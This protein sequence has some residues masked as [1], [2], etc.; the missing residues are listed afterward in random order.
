MIDINKAINTV[1]KYCSDN[2]P[3]DLL[4]IMRFEE[5]DHVTIERAKDH[6]GRIEFLQDVGAFVVYSAPFDNSYSDNIKRFSL[7]HELGHYFLELHRTLLVRGNSHNASDQFYH[8]EKFEQ[9]AD[10]FAG[11]LLIPPNY[12]MK[13]IGTKNSLTL[14]D[15][16]NIATECQT[17]LTCAVMRYISE[18]IEPCAL[19]LS[20]KNNSIYYNPSQK[21]IELG[22]KWWNGIKTKTFP[23]ESATDKA[24][25]N[26]GCDKIYERYSNT[27]IWYSPNGEEYKL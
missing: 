15:L 2:V 17:S 13:K 5:I 26:I 21:A 16:K 18:N 12:L 6:F 25:Q 7:A 24:Q 3:V 20:S 1:F 22:F 9:E 4:E 8:E 23:P 14:D 27:H 11:K 19:I 10:E